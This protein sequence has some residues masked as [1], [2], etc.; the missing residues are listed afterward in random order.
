MRV[1][2]EQRRRVLYLHIASKNRRI[3]PASARII[4]A[5]ATRLHPWQTAR[6]RKHHHPRRQHH[7]R[8]ITSISTAP[9]AQSTTSR[10][11]SDP[12]E[13]DRKENHTYTAMADYSAQKVPDL[14]KLLSERG[15]VISGNKADLIARLQEDD[16]K[17]NG[18]ATASGAGEDEIDWDEDDHK[19]AAEATTAP[20]AAAIA[21][22]G[23]GQVKTPIAVP[24]QKAAIDPST[25]NDLKVKQPEPAKTESAPAPA[26]D[27]EGEKEV[28]A[29]PE[30]PK[31]DYTIG[32]GLSEAEK[33]AEK[34][35]ARAKRFARPEAAAPTK[36]MTEEEKKLEE[37]AKKFGTDKVKEKEVVEDIV[38]GL[39][40]A[41][42]ERKLKRDRGGEGAQGRQAKRQTPD[43][44]TE[45]P[46]R[47]GG[48]G[49]QGQRG[50]GRGGERKTGGAAAGQG[51]KKITD[52]PE[53]RAKAEARAKRFAAA[54]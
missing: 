6:S 18:G 22:G 5:N 24:N 37:R 7:R 41:L 48:G 39:N 4:P 47:G 50:G 26:A 16:A 43:R 2:E 33:E 20:A 49:G 52:D 34:R 36:E 8:H 30:E 35:A 14:K 46:R 15:L 19:P 42:P 12:A 21:T 38:K 25:T 45:A 32:L 51:L 1:R 13:P 40:S 54:K 10:R 28:E 53:E 11:P 3:K 27:A 9:I 31:K 44:R 17:K 23:V 29:K